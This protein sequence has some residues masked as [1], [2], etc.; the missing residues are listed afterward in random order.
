MPHR[1]AGV[2]GGGAP[3]T[4]NGWVGGI[5]IPRQGQSPCPTVSPSVKTFGF[6][7]FLVR[8]RLG[9]RIISA[10]RCVTFMGFC[11]ARCPHRAA[12]PPSAPSL[13]GQPGKGRALALRGSRLWHTVGAAVP[14]GPQAPL[15]KGGQ[16]GR[17]QAAPTDPNARNPL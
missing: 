17:P 15:L 9:G 2:I 7:T 10:L 8:G 5:K 16:D 1:A 12:V 14:S 4:K 3:Y 11:R 6:A 13:K